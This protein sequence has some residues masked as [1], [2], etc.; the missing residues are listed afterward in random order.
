M[1]L[2]QDPLGLARDLL[3]FIQ[4]AKTPYHAVEEVTRRLRE[5]DFRA[6]DEREPWSLE[7][8]ARGFVV[9]GGSI[10]AFVVGSEPPAAAG[11]TI[12]GAH[13]D[14]PN[15]R[16]KP[17]PD[18]ENAGYRQLS[19]EV[20]GGVLLHTW[21][22]RDLT[23]AGRVVLADGSE[24]LVALEDPV[25]RI[26]SLAIHLHREVNREGLSLNAQQHLSPVVAL[27]KDASVSVLDR[28]VRAL[29]GGITAKDVL[30]FDL[31]LLEAQPG[32]IGGFDGEFLFSAR[33][34]NL[35]SCHAACTALLASGAVTRK[36]RVIALYDHEEVGS[37]SAVG[38]RSYFLESILER[39]ALGSPGATSDAKA[40]ALA[41]SLLVSADMAHAVHPNYADKHDKQHRPLLG[42]GPVLK[43]NVNQSYATDG[44]GA[45][46]FVAA[47]RA[48]DVRHQHFAARNDMPCGSTIGPITAARLGVRTVDVGNPMLSMHSCREMA[49]VAD[50]VPMIRVLSHMLASE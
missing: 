45:R 42:Q 44:A 7:A 50:V 38:A 9:R 14:S 13:T 41:Q 39:L 2:D 29:P 33:L 26:P 6:F 17:I 16:L 18:S 10:V 22:D 34:D 12:L 20:Y 4:A 31:S 3:R 24:R 36:T 49:A 23:L 15:L 46:A 48:V 40:R 1:Q 35:A 19:I 21:L 47:C 28:V 32:I 5:H 43:T 25:A 30:G 11:F 37:Q 8:G 27:D